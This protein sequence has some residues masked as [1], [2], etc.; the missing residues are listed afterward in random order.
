MLLN[1]KALV[2]FLINSSDISCRATTSTTVFVS[3]VRRWVAT[4]KRENQKTQNPLVHTNKGRKLPKYARRVSVEGEQSKHQVVKQQGCSSPFCG[5]SRGNPRMLR[6]PACGG[7]Y[8]VAWSKLCSI[9]CLLITWLM[10]DGGWRRRR[11]FRMFPSARLDSTHRGFL[12][13]DE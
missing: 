12:C 10:T 3:L 6:L 11:R 13:S 4:G 8:I 7:E 2:Q 5:A 9:A 1:P